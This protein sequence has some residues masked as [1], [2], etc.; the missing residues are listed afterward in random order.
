MS[1]RDTLLSYPLGALSPALNG[2]TVSYKLRHNTRGEGIYMANRNWASGGKLYSM[3]VMPVFVNATIQI[4]A[5]GAVTS[6]VGSA[7]SS[8]TLVSAGVYKVTLNPSTNF[9]RLYFADASI[10][11]PASG[12]SGISA[13]EIQNAPNASVAL[14]AG[15]QLEVT[16]LAATSSSVTTLV[17]TAPASGSAINLFMIC[18]NSSVV[19]DGE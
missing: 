1:P 13:V 2:E 19:I 12:N 18:S 11:S 16:C 4:G 5:S 14:I 6:F 17:P 7:V 9:T 8:V 15:A 3:H 10:Q